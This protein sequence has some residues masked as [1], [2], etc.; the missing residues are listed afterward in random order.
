MLTVNLTVQSVMAS[1]HPEHIEEI[2]FAD[3]N[4]KTVEAVKGNSAIFVTLKPGIAFEP[5]IGS[6]VLASGPVLSNDNAPA[7]PHAADSTAITDLSFRA[8]I[9]G[10]FDDSTGDPIIDA[11]VADSTSGTFARTTSTGTVSLAFLPLG[12]ST[13]RIRKAGYADLLLPVSIS[14]RDTL[15]LTLLLT[16]VK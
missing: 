9:V 11:E 6:Y 14:P 4:D 2:N 7:L 10:V 1:I 16:R 13:L 12:M 5:G 8:R 3:C 15:P